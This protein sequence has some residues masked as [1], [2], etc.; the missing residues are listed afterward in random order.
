M[1]LSARR[2]A[3][4]PTA[5]LSAGRRYAQITTSTPAAMGAQLNKR[6]KRLFSSSPLLHTPRA[7]SSGQAA[8]PKSA[9]KFSSFASS[10]DM[11]I[12][13]KKE[14]TYTYALAAAYSAKDVPFNPVRHTTTFQP[15]STP[16]S[17]NRRRLPRSQRPASGQDA[18]FI[19]QHKNAR[20]G[21]AFGVADGVGG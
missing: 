8:E 16:P 6:P 2:V 20:T 14:T 13:T 4:T 18:Y 19:S 15:S 10:S 11:D 1:V 17:P 7:A 9:R 5:L 21:Y 3:A 12:D